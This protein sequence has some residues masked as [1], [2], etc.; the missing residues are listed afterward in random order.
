MRLAGRFV[1]RGMKVLHSIPVVA[2]VD[3]ADDLLGANLGLKLDALSAQDAINNAPR[4]NVTLNGTTVSGALLGSDCRGGF[5]CHT[6][7]RMYRSIRDP[8]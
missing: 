7:A 2:L 6:H 8:T 1:A 3:V 4:L 5:G